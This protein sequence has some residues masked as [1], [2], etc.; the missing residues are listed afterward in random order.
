[1]LAMFF[2]DIYS[3]LLYDLSFRGLSFISCEQDVYWL[4]ERLSRISIPW[5]APFFRISIPWKAESYI[6]S[7]IGTVLS[8]CGTFVA[9]PS[10]KQV[11]ESCEVGIKKA[12]N[13]LSWVI[14]CRSYCPFCTRR[15]STT[16]GRCPSSSAPTGRCSTSC[17]DTNSTSTHPSSRDKRRSCEPTFW[18]SLISVVLLRSGRKLSYFYCFHIQLLQNSY[19]SEFAFSF[20][21]NSSASPSLIQT[22]LATTI[23][24]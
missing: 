21:Q 23:F 16:G 24:Q 2:V 20:F 19:A 9:W 15:S 13:V 7:L 6:N 8:Y 4:A 1:M 17:G 3:Q 10:N 18:S 22:G 5:L 11:L 12:E 14:L